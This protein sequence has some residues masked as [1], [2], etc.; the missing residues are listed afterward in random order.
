M[1]MSQEKKTR[2]AYPSYDRNNSIRLVYVYEIP[3][4]ESTSVS[5]FEE[6]LYNGKLG[7]R[8]TGTK[9]SNC[10]RIN[11]ISMVNGNISDIV[12][13]TLVVVNDFLCS[14]NVNNITTM[15]AY[16]PLCKK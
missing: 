7:T 3:N 14:I 9:D 4:Y 12:H 1:S 15:Y 11:D 8:Y 5:N 2:A 10:I 6:L 13:K 16:V